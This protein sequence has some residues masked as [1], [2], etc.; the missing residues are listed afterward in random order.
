MRLNILITN[1]WSD[2]ADGGHEVIHANWGASQK[3]GLDI[4][5]RH[6]LALGVRGEGR[7]EATIGRALEALGSL[8]ATHWH[9]EGLIDDDGDI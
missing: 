6:L 5:E 8:A 7:G 2:P 9:H 1:G 3:V 4:H